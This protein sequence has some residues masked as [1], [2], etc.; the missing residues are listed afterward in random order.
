[1][2]LKKFGTESKIETMGVQIR[3][4]E[5]CLLP[6]FLPIKEKKLVFKTSKLP[7]TSQMKWNL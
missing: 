5:P 7:L 3:Y 6:F 2:E 1:L 4:F